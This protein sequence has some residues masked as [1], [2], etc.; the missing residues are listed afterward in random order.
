[1]RPESQIRKEEAGKPPYS[2]YRFKL[3]LN[4][5]AEKVVES[6]DWE[7]ILLWNQIFNAALKDDLE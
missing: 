5:G 6:P 1:M 7:L 4:R 3:N 2:Y